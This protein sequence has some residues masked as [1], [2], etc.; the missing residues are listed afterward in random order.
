MFAK[1]VKAILYFVMVKVFALTEVLG[2]PG[3]KIT[4]PE[5]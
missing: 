1:S 3:G 5:S 2:W 4:G